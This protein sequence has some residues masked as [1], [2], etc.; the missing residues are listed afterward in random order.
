MSWAVMAFSFFTVPP[1]GVL[2]HG[3]YTTIR[4]LERFWANFSPYG[5]PYDVVSDCAP[6]GVRR[7]A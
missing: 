1:E 6:P 4:Y 3:V 5:I 2:H 7:G